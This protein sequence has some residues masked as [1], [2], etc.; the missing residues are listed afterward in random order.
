MLERAGYE[1]SIAHRFGNAGDDIVGEIA[2]WHPDLVVIG[3]RGLRGV[4]RWL[5]S[6][7]ERVIHRA[8]VPLLVVP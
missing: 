1:V 8:N 3:K 4:Q 6:V 5:G 2:D 7:S